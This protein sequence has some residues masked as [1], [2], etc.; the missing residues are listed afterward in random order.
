GAFLLHANGKTIEA[1]DGRE[2]APAAATDR[3]FLDANGKPLPR[4]ARGSTRGRASRRSFASGRRDAG[5]ARGSARSCARAGA[6]V[7]T[8]AASKAHVG[9]GRH[10]QAANARPPFRARWSSPMPAVTIGEA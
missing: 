1:Y 5:A 9:F 10:G 8:G 2:T 6:F 7:R 4:A 3:L